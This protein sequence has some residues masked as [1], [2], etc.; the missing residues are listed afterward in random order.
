MS[1]AGAKGL[2]RRLHRPALVRRRLQHAERR[3]A[4]QVVSA[5]RLRPL[6][7]A[8][9][10]HRV[11]TDRLLRRR[12]TLPDRPGSRPRSSRPPPG[13]WTVCHGSS[14]TP[15]SGCRPRTASRAAGCSQRRGGEAAGEGVR[16]GAVRW[17]GASARLPQAVLTPRRSCRPPSGRNH[18]PSRRPAPTAWGRRDVAYEPGEAEHDRGQQGGTGGAPRASHW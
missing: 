9:L 4:A 6:P 10:A 16:G 7:Q 8:H 1:G 5:G 11:R 2:P 15:G 3:R 12:G 13:C 14:A 18:R 17:R